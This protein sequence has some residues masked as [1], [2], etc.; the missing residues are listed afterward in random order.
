MLNTEKSKWIWNRH[1][2]AEDKN[3]PGLMLFRKEINVDREVKNCRINISADTKYKL[4]VNGNLVEIG[5]SRGDKQVWFYETVELRDYLNMGV[6]CIAVVVLRYPED[7]AKGNHGMFRTSTPGLYIDGEMSFADGSSLPLVTDE[8]WK[9]IKDDRTTFIREEERFA[10]LII[11]EEVYG[12][13]FYRAWKMPGYQDMLWDNAF[14]YAYTAVPETVSPGN[15]NP[16]DIPSL[17][18]I[19]RKFKDVSSI[20]MS[21]YSADEWRKFLAGDNPLTIPAHSR[22]IIEIDAGEE[23]TGFPHAAFEGGM[24]AKV[25][26]LYSEAYVQNEFEGPEH[27]PVKKDREDKRNGHLTGYSDKY[28]LYGEGDEKRAENYLPFWFR[29]F[30]FIQITI[31]TA[32]DPLI[33]VSYNYRETGYPLEIRTRVTTSDPVMAGIQEISE[34]TLR[35]CMHETYED[36]PYYE[37]LQYLMDTRAEMLFTYQMSGDDRLARK[38]ITDMQRAQRYDGLLNCNYPNCNSNVIPGFSLYYIHMVHDHMMYFGDRDL[39]KSSIPTIEGILDFFHRNLNEQGLVAKIG[40]LLDKARFWS[41]IDWAKEWN[42][43]NGMPSAGLTGPL[44]MESLMYVYGL[45]KAVDLLSYLGRLDQ[46]EAYS[47][48]AAFVQKAVLTHCM[49]KRGML[50]DGPG[51]EQ[52]SQHCQVFAALTGTGDRETLKKN[53]V[54]TI[55]DTSYTQC[56]IAMRFYLF[57]AL[58]KLDIYELTEQFW[59]PWHIMLDNHCTTCVES[60]AYARSEC[61]GWGAIALYELPAV[62]LGVTPASPGYKTIR[63]RPVAGYMT[64]ARGEVITP[65]GMVHVEWKLIDGKMHVSYTAPEGVEVVTE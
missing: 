34:R 58:E 24:N 60:E 3:E 11:H 17:Y 35:R 44:T 57:R 36:C 50:T 22:E 33:F 52:Y 12:N 62:T 29:T 61:H 55:K 13:P 48:E 6:N 25:T 64:W 59:K 19:K 38:C 5:P 51:I 41:F 16:R 37:Q 21:R 42:D 10:P 63:I 40:G 18:K 26:F 65:M 53:L 15:L 47:R 54:T 39:V 4:F 20:R 27:I 1:W 56:A 32:D 31:E 28:H 49:G 30:R 9:C 2:S 7:P 43:T 14:A 45:Q 46:A 8:T 23:M